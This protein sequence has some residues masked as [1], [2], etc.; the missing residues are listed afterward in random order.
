MTD[1]LRLRE[2]VVH[3]LDKVVRRQPALGHAEVHRPARGD[4]PEAELA[5]R[6]QLCLHNPRSP[7]G[8]DVVVVEDGRA[9]REGELGEARPRRRVLGLGVD[10]GPEG[11]ERAQP[12][13]EVGLLRARSG[14]RLV[15]V[16][17]SVDEAGGDEGAPEVDH[18][19]GSGRR[20]SARCLDEA[21]RDEHPPVRVLI[22]GAVARRDVR[23]RDEEGQGWTDSSLWNRLNGFPSVSQQRANQPT[24]GIG[25]FSSARPPSS[26][27]RA[28]VSSM[29][30]V[31]K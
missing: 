9:P 13:K 30:S 15:Q 20:T 12:G 16:V 1:A 14:Q 26:L 25:C 5:R 23:V 7:R 28:K 3:V 2:R 31:S 8:E 6:L 24:L 21:V 27:A 17:V 4:D 29:S 11:V 10:P 22:A 19:V 18:L